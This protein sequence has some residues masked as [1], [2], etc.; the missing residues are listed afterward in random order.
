MQPEL[1]HELARVVHIIAKNMGDIIGMAIFLLLAG[2]V[3][4]WVK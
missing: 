4:R 3:R 2:E 1:S